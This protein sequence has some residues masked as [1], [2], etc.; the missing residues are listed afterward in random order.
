MYN[1]RCQILILEISMKNK[2]YTEVIKVLEQ[3]DECD[4]EKIPKNV[5]EYLKNNMDDNYEF[6]LDLEE[7]NI[8]NAAC[9]ILVDIYSKYIANDIE[10]NTINDILFLNHRKNEIKKEG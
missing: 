1:K 9:G 4:Y 10:K 5:I 7:M 3:I 2:I 6:D 8:S